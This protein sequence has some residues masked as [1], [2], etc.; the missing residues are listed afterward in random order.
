MQ[1]RSRCSFSRKVIP[2]PSFRA[3]S[4]VHRG[5]L[6]A[7]ALTPA[8]APRRCNFPAPSVDCI[9]SASLSPLSIPPAPKGLLSKGG[10]GQGPAR[11]WIF[12]PAA[13]AA[14]QAKPSYPALL[15]LAGATASQAGRQA[16]S[17]LAACG[18]AGAFPFS[19]TGMDSAAGLCSRRD[20]ELPPPPVLRLAR[21]GC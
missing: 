6:G 4:P 19:T 1:V 9:Y 14:L 11:H 21:L 13:E 15:I 18:G 8:T 7:W 2:S 10:F 17:K 20:R 16:G 12:S 5:E 3:A